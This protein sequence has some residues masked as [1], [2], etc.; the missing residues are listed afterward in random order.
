MKEKIY[1][2]SCFFDM[3]AEIRRAISG[4]FSCIAVLLFSVWLLLVGKNFFS[5]IVA[6]AVGAISITFSR[7][8]SAPITLLLLLFVFA[9]TSALPAE[10]DLTVIAS[11][12]GC[13]LCVSAIAR[14]SAEIKNKKALWRERILS[15]V[16]PIISMIWLQ[17]NHSAILPVVLVGT[18]A[19]LKLIGKANCYNIHLENFHTMKKI[20][21]EEDRKTSAEIEDIL[22]NYPEIRIDEIVTLE[23]VNKAIAINLRQRVLLIIL[24]RRT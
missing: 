2:L 7:M 1:K 22:L 3:S 6:V 17:L 20:F 14:V 13:I 4:Y 5:P 18:I 9:P 21:R 24:K 16:I 12:I 8:K 15:S 23:Q 19:I 11:I 10:T